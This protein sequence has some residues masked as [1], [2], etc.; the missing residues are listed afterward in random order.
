[1]IISENILTSFNKET[2]VISKVFHPLLVLLK[3]LSSVMVEAGFVFRKL[4]RILSL[5]L[6]KKRI[7]SYLVSFSPVHA[8]FIFRD[9]VTDS[10]LLLFISSKTREIQI[11]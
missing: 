7:G 2:V 3:G 5:L 1:M 4:L 8:Y 11:P 6:Q 10:E 9:T